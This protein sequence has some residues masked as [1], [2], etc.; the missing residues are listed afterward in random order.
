MASADTKIH[1]STDLDVYC[2]QVAL[3][4]K[5]ASRELAAISGETKIAW[6]Q[7]SAQLLSGDIG[8]GTVVKSLMRR[9]DQVLSAHETVMEEQIARQGV[10]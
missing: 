6:L 10:V 3:R 1:N 4:A 2:Q 9:L 5:A 8:P 7:R